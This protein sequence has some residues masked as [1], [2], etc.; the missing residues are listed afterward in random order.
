MND[1]PWSDAELEIFYELANRDQDQFL[2]PP[3]PLPPKHQ[4]Q[5]MG[6][7]TPTQ[8]VDYQPTFNPRHHNFTSQMQFKQ[9]VVAKGPKLSLPEF[10]GTGILMDGLGSLKNSLSLLLFLLRRGLK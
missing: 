1:C 6:Q 2:D 5:P 8:P 7:F 3:V 10:D 4:Q 9:K